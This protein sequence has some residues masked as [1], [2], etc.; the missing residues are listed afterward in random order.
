MKT[1][2]TLRECLEGYKRFNAWELKEQKREL[3][4]LT[5]EESLLQFFELCDLARTLAP[6]AERVFLEQ[7]KAHWIAL[8]Q[9][10]QRV[11]QAMTDAP[12]T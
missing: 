11:A 7:D 3:P 6:N 4:W 10:F 2:P 12:T 8:H 1:M 5:V 9:K